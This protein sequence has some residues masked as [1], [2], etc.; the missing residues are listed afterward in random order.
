M[1]ILSSFF[2]MIILQAQKYG[3]KK[4]P[5]VRRRKR[6]YPVFGK[7]VNE[8]TIIRMIIVSNLRYFRLQGRCLL[9][10]LSM[11]MIMGLTAC[12]GAKPSHEPGVLRVNIGAEPPGLDWHTATDSTSFD[13]VSNIMVGLTQYTEDVKCAPACAES[14]D[15]S[16]DGKSYLFHLRNDV[17]W[18]DG[19]KV[20]AYDFEYAWKRLLD[21]ATAGQYAFFLYDIEKAKEFNTGKLKDSAQVGVR[22]LSP[23]ILE[24]KLKKPAAY[25]IYLT[26]FCAS[27]PMRKDV[28][29]KYGN[30][31]TEPGNLVSNGPFKLKHW[32][33]EYKIELVAN[34]NFFEGAPK[35]KAIK[36]FMV[37]EQSTA[38][39]LYEN[40]ELD[41]IDN[42]SFSTPDV[43]RFAHS[44]E[45]RS[46]PLL[47]ENYLAFNVKKKPFDNVLVRQ[48]VAMSIDKR[49][50][51]KILRRGERP[52]SSFIP[53][54][55]AGASVDAG[56]PFAP[57]KARELLRQ[58][59]YASGAQIP[60]VDMLYP[61]REDVRLVVEA[62]Q[63]QLK[64]NLGL[65][66]NLVNQEWKVYLATLRKDAP[67]IYR[68]SWGADFP[69]PETFMNLFTSYNGNND[70]R[71]S[72]LEYD[73]LIE[74]AQAQA[75]SEKR[76]ALYRKADFLLCS[77]AC[78][79]VPI[80]LATQN[81]MVKPWVKGIAVNPL[82][83]QFFKSVVVF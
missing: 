5:P 57:Q 39:A 40:D 31:W 13:V 25:F 49:V 76:A 70:T 62:I 41:Y 18:S 80:F 71:W 14:W 8:S 74:E 29:E 4:E 56:L 72:S 43:E 61:N 79:I 28:V 47:R 46:F 36:M 60:P 53:P 9:T 23:S 69:D 32:Q 35:L 54:G 27:F 65:R 52:S 68:N 42:R 2:A 58:A 11:L 82:D 45:Y 34:E 15:I 20:T 1:M 51:P 50:F 75:D 67:P 66:L 48:A 21:P 30:R 83:L 64:Q 7:T 10:F 63:D 44:P 19:K 37:P 55:L 26:A 22:A 12:A 17:L 77:K 81:V 24:V 59:G 38:F 6:V 3:Q 16:K 33:H 73:A 78:P